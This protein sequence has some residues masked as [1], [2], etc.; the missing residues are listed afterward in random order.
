[1]A[2]II[3]LLPDSVANQI[4]A[5][6]VV[7][8]PA[9]VVKELMEN[10]IDA[11]S[12]SI[13]LIVR[14]GGKA[15][16]QVIDDG[17]GMSETDA[18]LS[19]ER[20]ATSKIRQANDLFDIRTMGFR[21]EALASIAAVAEV[22]LRTRR[23]ADELGTHVQIN[24]SEF[25][26]QQPVSCAVG[27]NFSV[28]NLFFNIPARR[29]F[30]KGNSVELKHIISEFQ[31]VALAYPEIAMSLAHNGADIYRLN[32]TT[33]K[34]R[35]VGLF[36]KS[37]NPQLLDITTQTTIVNVD[38]F[39]GK[40]E[41]AKKSPG[42]QFFF[43]NGRFMKNP[44]LNRAVINAY[45]RLLPA[46]SIPTY[47]IYLDIDPQNIDVNIHPTKTEIKF[48]DERMIW[49]ILHAAVKETLGKFAVVPSI[50]F[51][52]DPGFSI[53]FF[54]KN[55]PVTPPEIDVNP[56]FNPFDDEGAKFSGGSFAAKPHHSKSSEGWES[57]YAD[58]PAEEEPM[59]LTLQTFASKGFDDNPAE[60][61]AKFYQ[62]KGRY[63]LTTVKSGLMVID[64]KRAHERILF[65]QYLESL[66]S[67]HNIAQRELYPQTIELSA[68]DFALIM[69]SQSELAQMGL[70]VSNLGHNTI[71]VNSMPANL[72]SAEPAKLI[73][74]LLL[75]IKE[76][77][78]LPFDDA[79]QKIAASMAKAGAIGYSRNLTPFEMQELVDKLFACNHPNFSPDGKK[80]LTIIEMDELDKKLR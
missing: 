54:P 76:S 28:K 34:Q 23:A 7:Q 64:Q 63:I 70:E 16:I 80:V 33:L 11:G 2:D 19:F 73:D 65:E 17:S 13:Q 50:D 42:E 27:T 26:C 59:Q 14:D 71:G 1:M 4:A 60:S 46:D 20:H 9:S 25:V 69:D 39:I 21:G 24:G 6:E 75:E 72:K 48:E 68:Q 3:Q 55:A 78:A 22:E 47:F 79:R 74:G 51:D 5:G 43:V 35:I 77:Q 36:G 10:S 58:K 61:S 15:L 40:P 62:V 32:A 67:A 38:G 12:K 57:L 30:L 53:P 45:N 29:K 31:R 52:S 66:T 44:F 49:Q 8:R 18:R 37:I 56:N 41:C